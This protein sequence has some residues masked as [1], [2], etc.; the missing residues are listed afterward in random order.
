MRKNRWI[1]APHREVS[2]TLAAAMPGALGATAGD[3]VWLGSDLLGGTFAF[4]PFSAYRDGRVTNPNVVVLGQIGRGKSTFVKTLLLRELERGRSAV[5]L[6]PKGEYGGLAAAVGVR[7]VVVAPSGTTRCNP[8]LAGHDRAAV[9]RDVGVIALLVAHGL[10]RTLTPTERT[11]LDVARSSC[12]TPITLDTVVAALLAPTVAATQELGLD[13]AALLESGREIAYE[14]LRFTRGDL[15]GMLNGESTQDVDFSAPLVVID[16]SA[17]WGTEALAPVMAAIIATV[18]Q[19]GAADPAPRYFVLDE[20]W[21]VLSDP[22]I[23]RWLQGSWKLARATATA[24]IC[25]LHR[26]A[27]CVSAGA[28]GSVERHLAAG[29]LA[30]SG[31]VVSFSLDPSDAADAAHTV[32]LSNPAAQLL[33]KL[34]RGLAIIRV[35]REHHL[36]DIQID[37]AAAAVSESDA[38]MWR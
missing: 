30:D 6:D 29:L 9:R 20:A 23:A 5:V 31:T 26:V 22:R 1:P 19:V 13:R 17:I 8:L 32:G 3:G 33:P 34:R 36:V 24:N 21:A 4:D 14:L 12:A 35:G 37:G 38:A 15:A 25:V 27:D 28:S 11:A 18:Q 7:P 16:C 10:G 2:S